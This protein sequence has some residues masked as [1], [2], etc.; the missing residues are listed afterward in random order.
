MRPPELLVAS[1]AGYNS[2]GFRRIEQTH[3][4][5]LT[6]VTE[7]YGYPDFL[8][9]APNGAV[10]F[11]LQQKLPTG[12]N[13]SLGR[14]STTPSSSASSIAPAP[15]CRP[16]SPTSSCTPAR[17]RPPHYI[18]GPVIE[19]G[20]LIGV[21]IFQLDNRDVFQHFNDYTGLGDTGETVVSQPHRRPGRGRQSAAPR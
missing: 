14:R 4:P 12:S 8:L 1:T 10:I 13:L 5:I 11:S 18:A 20:A 6:Y 3:R 19:A 17:A 9:V 16:R 15:S 2:A 7:A 21:A